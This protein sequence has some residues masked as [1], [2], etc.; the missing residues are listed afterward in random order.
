MPHLS[1]TILEPIAF[2]WRDLAI[3]LVLCL[4]CSALG[5][6]RVQYFVSLG[7]G[8]SIAAQ[9]IVM[10]FLHGD[11]LRDWALVQA[12]LLL[13]Y[14]LRLGVFLAMRE[15]SSPYKAVQA[16]TVARGAKIT[17][18][19]KGAM[20]LGVSI[21]YVVMFLPALLIM[22]AQAADQ[23]LPSVPYGVAIMVIGLGT[24]AL[25]DWQK[26]RYKKNSPAHFC[27]VGLFRV[28]RFPNYLGE[29]VFWFGV[30][31][32]AMSA[33]QSVLGWVI[34]SLGFICIE[35]VMLGSSRR[36]E[37]KQASRYGKDAAFQTYAS[38]TPILLPFL[39]VY[40]LQNL[41]VY[42]G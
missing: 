9:A 28:V 23:T 14:G 1:Y 34:G 29:M 20:W 33:Y 13:A 18:W 22:S 19:A 25:A 4:V 27:N 16:E 11:T 2:I 10:S 39:P 8:L 35:L 24:E 42:L 36:L 32:S 26:S 12:V 7:Y 21:L 6:K 15:K 40:S 30:W 38:Q 5:F 37:A 3:C 41:K 31:I 17:G